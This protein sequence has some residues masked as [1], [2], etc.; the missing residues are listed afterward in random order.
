MFDVLCKRKYSDDRREL[1]NA[2]LIAMTLINVNR[3]K[4]KKAVKIEDIIGKD[5]LQEAKL[6]DETEGVDAVDILKSLHSK[7]EGKAQSKTTRI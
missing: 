7:A 2:A 5:A 4:N 1:T 6:Q 3:P